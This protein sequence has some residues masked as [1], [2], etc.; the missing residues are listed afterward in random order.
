MSITKGI[1][2]KIQVFLAYRKNRKAY[3]NKLIPKFEYELRKQFLDSVEQ[4]GKTDFYQNYPP[5][6]ISGLRSSI[7][8]FNTYK[9]EKYLSKETELL[10]IGG[11][12]GFFTA[13]LSRFVKHIDLVEQNEKLTKIGQ[14]LIDFEKITN[15]S[16]QNLDFKKFETNKKYDFVM[17]LAIHMWVGLPI[18]E[19]LNRLHQLLKKGGFL[20]FESHILHSGKTLELNLKSI[21]EVSSIFEI[22]EVGEVDDHEGYLR[23]FYILKAI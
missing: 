5:L 4:F 7:C 22:I 1:V 11:N 9:L 20:L 6:K 18:D 10:D 8:R 19:Y 2:D 16:I 13:Y 12:I 17:S 14:K 15:V 23:D 3:K 21:F